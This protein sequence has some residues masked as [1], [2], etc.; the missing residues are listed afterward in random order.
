MTAATP[1]DALVFFGATGDLAY[2]MIFPALY[3]MA[4]R[5]H[6]NFPI[7][8]VA[9]SN[10]SDDQLRKRARDSIEKSGQLDEAVFAK[11]AERL[12]Y[13][14]GNYDDAA[15][16]THL[17]EV[18]GESARP[19]HYLA[20]PP[21]MFEPVIKGLESSG[22]AKNA[23]IVIEKPFGRDLASAKA[24]NETLHSV[25]PENAIFRIDHYLGK[26]SVENL[27]YFRFANA[28]LT[29][30]WCRE[31]VQ[32]IQITMA[33][34]IGVQGRGKFY[35]EVGA[36]RD[37][38]QNHLL[39]VIA[40]LAMEAPADRGAAALHD[41][42]LR[43]FNAMQAF[44]P[45]DVIRGQFRGYLDEEGVPADS[46]VETFAALRLHIDTPRWAGVPFYIRA[47]KKL[48]VRA[49]EVLVTL[50]PLVNPIFD[51]ADV[52]QANYF[53][54]RLSPD[55]SISAGV[56]VKAAGQGML[57]KPVELF[58]RDTSSDAMGPYER[59]LGD[60]MRGDGSLFTSDDCV[61]AAWRVVAPVID[62]H[63]SVTV[64]EPGTWGPTAAAGILA[65]GDRWHDP[66]PKAAV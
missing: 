52:G 33:E 23:R 12:H 66:A 59:L 47:G 44:K 6:L 19:L 14:S 27:L 65:T 31:H 41:E 56:R 7:I 5:G 10:W 53:R 36:I 64:Y 58:A 32:S 43:V 34:D 22:C 18:L 35:E 24:L 50:K 21:S 40:L 48:P 49:T 42:K 57:G 37:V 39:Q 29:P 63:M 20:V 61:E 3:A 9:R 8:G 55:I 46:Q 51:Q 17:R 11:L 28:M 4:R 62:Q 45:E 54:F 38:V 16:Y 25:F 1:S 13:L 2:Q 26:E 60:A 15:T 30:L